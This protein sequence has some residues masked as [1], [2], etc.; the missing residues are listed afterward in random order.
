MAI[1]S[2]CLATIYIGWIAESV[3]HALRLMGLVIGAWDATWKCGRTRTQ[4]W[5]RG[6]ARCHFQHTLA[7]Q[8]TN[9]PNANT[10]ATTCSDWFVSVEAM[11]KV[12]GGD[13]APPLFLSGIFVGIA[14]RFCPK[15]RPPVFFFSH[16]ILGA[17]ARGK[18]TG[19]SVQCR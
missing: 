13:F 5:A 8:S 19:E 16:S 3:P 2:D 4:M 9:H 11:C 12:L 6:L 17:S 15:T 14:P 7:D 1:W 10:L 18:V